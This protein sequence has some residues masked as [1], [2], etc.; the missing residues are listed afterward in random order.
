MPW[1]DRTT[2]KKEDEGRVGG[3]HEGDGREGGG[4]EGHDGGAR[5]VAADTA[6][7]RWPPR[8]RPWRRRRPH[9]TH[10][11][12]RKAQTKVSL[13]QAGEGKRGESSPGR[14]HVVGGTRG[15]STCGSRLLD[16]VGHDGCARSSRSRRALT[17]Q[18]MSTTPCL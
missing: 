18:M 8:R 7:E 14:H 15:R 4:R 9:R 13:C 10:S 1:N 16:R 11:L 3:G 6:N 12:R 17:S 5:R 2:E